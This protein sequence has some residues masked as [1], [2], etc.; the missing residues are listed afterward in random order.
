MITE[1]KTQLTDDARRELDRILTNYKQTLLSE[2]TELKFVPGEREVEITASDL[3]YALQRL[4]RP[5]RRS[6]IKALIVSSYIT[7][8]VLCLLAGLFWESLQHA[9]QSQPAKA[10]LIVVGALMSAAGVALGVWLKRRTSFEV[11]QELDRLVRSR[12]EMM[13]EFTKLEELA[14]KLKH[15][16]SSSGD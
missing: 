10:L 4:Q 16:A 2:I 3:R 14:E 1:R 9:F 8:G 6:N 11:Y 13:H 5:G 7:V 12:N 15:K